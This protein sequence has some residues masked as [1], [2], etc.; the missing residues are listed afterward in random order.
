M[1]L[2][3]AAKDYI[4]NHFG[5]GTPKCFVSSGISYTDPAGSAAT[6][7]TQ[8]V[9]ATLK[10]NIGGN[11]RGPGG[12][13]Y[14]DIPD[15][16]SINDSDISAIGTMTYCVGTAPPPT[17]CTVGTK[18][19]RDNNTVEQCFA[20]TPNYW[21]TVQT[22]GTGY[23]CVNGSCVPESTPTPPPTDKPVTEPLEV[24]VGGGISCSPGAPSVNLDTSGAFAYFKATPVTYVGV[25]DILV[26]NLSNSCFA[27]FA[28]EM[29]MWDGRAGTT[30]PIT[31]PERQEISRFLGEISDKKVISVTR[32]NASENK[33]IGASFEIPSSL[34]GVKTI[35]LSLWG[36][37]SKQALL[38]EL[39]SD[40][41]YAE[42]IPW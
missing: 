5:S 6:G 37:F 22:C 32:T 41:G 12:E 28:W 25:M 16:T 19:C 1:S 33:M 15:W 27:Y 18:R 36:N 8:D 11:A 23:K 34:E 26:H 20:G 31:S 10:M 14:I 13:V 17:G 7:S 29:R 21:R 2:S 24:Y 39:L 40:G 30:C 3:T 4:A 35:C 42:E 9:V 38:D